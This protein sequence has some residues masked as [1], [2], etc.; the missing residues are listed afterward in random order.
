ML[1]IILSQLY[2]KVS[3]FIMEPSTDKE[4]SERKKYSESQKCKKVHE[5][6]KC[7]TIK[8]YHGYEAY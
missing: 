2:G 4:G 5:T 3:W 6:H 8:E 7:A 1:K